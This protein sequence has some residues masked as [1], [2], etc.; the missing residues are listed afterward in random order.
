[1]NK[2]ALASLFNAPDLVP[3]KLPAPKMEPWIFVVDAEDP[4]NMAYSG[5]APVH[6]L[7]ESICERPG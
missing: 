2:H 5:G 6:G 1:M 7:H 4:A 3:G